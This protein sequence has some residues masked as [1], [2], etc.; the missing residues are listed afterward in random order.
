MT[1][2]NREALIRAVGILEGLMFATT[3]GVS[4]ALELVVNNIDKVLEDDN[5]GT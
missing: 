1:T 2:E 3:D 4:D 5:D